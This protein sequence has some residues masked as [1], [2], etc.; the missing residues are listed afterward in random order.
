MA[1]D[2]LP[3]F[4]PGE[5]EGSLKIH[6]KQEEQDSG[7]ARRGLSS[8]RPVGPHAMMPT[9][10][11][12][13][14]AMPAGLPSQPFLSEL[15]VRGGSHLSTQMV[16]ADINT[17]QQ[18]SFVEGGNMGTV[19][20]TAIHHGAPTL[21]MS[22]I[23]ASP[24]DAPDRRQSLVFSPP[25]DFQ[26]PA[27]TTMYSQHWQSSSAAPSNSPMYTSFAH[28][29]GAPAPTYGTQPAIG[30]QQNQQQYMPQPY[31]PMTRTPS[32]GT[33][34]G[35]IFRPGVNQQG[36]GHTQGYSGYLPPDTRGMPT[37][38]INAKV[39]TIPRPQMQ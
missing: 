18:S 39:E 33:N 14:P 20:N 17:E 27:N 7:M 13:G 16:H 3:E 19:G 38:G 5:T 32:F 2:K 15:P 11:G 37:P 34:Q 35:Q 9:H 29:Q 12:P 4:Y 8:P 25:T 10:S 22:E 6:E 24:H 30:L 28:Q 21:P 1:D 31:D 26:A 23:L 36:V